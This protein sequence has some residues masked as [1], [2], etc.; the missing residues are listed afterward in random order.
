M[1][2]IPKAKLISDIPKER[3][4]SVDGLSVPKVGDILE[5]DQ[6]FTS[7]N[8]SAMVLAYHPTAGGDDSYEIEVYETEI[9]LID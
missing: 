3:Y 1:S 6:G 7:E 9:K 5:L 2:K 4:R 8:G